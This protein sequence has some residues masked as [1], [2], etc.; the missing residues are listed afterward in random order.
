MNQPISIPKGEWHRV[1]KGNGK[2]TLKI[3]KEESTQYNIEGL[4]LTNTIDRPQK[5]ILS[6]IRSL[7]G[8][9]IVSS[10]DYDLSGETSAFSN[11]NY[12]TILKIKVDPH[13][14]PDG[15]KDEDLQQLFTDIRAI[16]GVR[17]FK[18]NKS[19]EKKTV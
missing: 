7:P 11:P 18:L 8:I 19:V 16:K 10:K 3:I 1:I 15:F 13:P 9:T 17:N 12:Y 14:Y 6:D 5:D 4:L 2:L